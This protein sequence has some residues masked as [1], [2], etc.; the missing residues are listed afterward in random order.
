MIENEELS[1]FKGYV[2][3]VNKLDGNAILKLNLGVVIV[4]TTFWS[5]S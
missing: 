4:I 5:S 1:S 3:R 2:Y